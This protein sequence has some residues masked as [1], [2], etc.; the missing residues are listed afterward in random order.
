MLLPRKEEKYWGQLW[1]VK[2][3]PK[4]VSNGEGKEVAVV[5][6]ES[7]VDEALLTELSGPN[8]VTSPGS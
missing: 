1:V 2:L 3:F 8:S 4:L 7:F 5:V 6:D